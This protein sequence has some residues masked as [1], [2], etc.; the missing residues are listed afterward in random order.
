MNEGG[1]RNIESKEFVV[2]RIPDP[3]AAINGTVT[4]GQISTGTLKAVQGIGA[5]LKDFYF[6][7]V[8]F[9]VT[10]FECVYI[11]RRQDARIVINNGARFN[12]Q[13]SGFIQG[14][15]PGDQIIF[16]KIKAS[17]PDGSTRNLNSIPLEIK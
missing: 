11:P 8:R 13:V 6:Q 2:K 14:C 17:G 4:E 1:T 10:S 15:K 5:V 16:R 7:G 9:D 3:I 12:S